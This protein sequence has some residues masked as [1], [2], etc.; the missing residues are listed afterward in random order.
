[1]APR[2][3]EDVAAIAV[4][5][6]AAADFRRESTAARLVGAGNNTPVT[7]LVYVDRGTGTAGIAELLIF[8]PVCEFTAHIV[9]SKSH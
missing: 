9:Q 1:M 3:V 2:A 7:V 5:G 6:S 4:T 8:H